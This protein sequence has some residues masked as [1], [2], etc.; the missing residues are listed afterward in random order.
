MSRSVVTVLLPAFMYLC[1][2]STAGCVAEIEDVPEVD[3]TEMEPLDED[4]NVTTSVVKTD[5]ETRELIWPPP[6]PGCSSP[7]CRGL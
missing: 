6:S 3:S 5:D 2:S 4:T 7:D 1:V